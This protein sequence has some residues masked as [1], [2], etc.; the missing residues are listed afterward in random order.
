[1][2]FRIFD[3]AKRL[4]EDRCQLTVLKSWRPPVSQKSSASQRLCGGF[5]KELLS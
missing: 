4:N 2:T 3:L 5:L 1:M